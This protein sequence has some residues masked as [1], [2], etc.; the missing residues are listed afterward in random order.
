MLILSTV[1]K[2]YIILDVLKDVFDGIM[3]GLYSAFLWL[4]GGLYTVATVVFELF[5][6]LA[7]GEL[8]S[9]DSYRLLVQNFYIVIGIIM[10]FFLAF[11]ILKGMVNPEEQKKG[12]TAVKTIIIN[13]VTSALMLAVLPSI[14]AFA[15]DF[16]DAIIVEQNTIG[17]F[18]GFGGEGD[19]TP[20]SNLKKVKQGAYQIVNGVYTAFFTVN[21]D[22][23]AE[24]SIPDG[25]SEK[26]K[27][28]YCQGAVVANKT[29]LEA[30]N[31]VDQNGNFNNYTPFSK[32]IV[33]NKV[34]FNFLLALVAGALLIYVGVSYCFDMA[35]RLIKLVF[36]QL[37]A[38]IPIFMR[39]IPDGKMS[40]VFGTW[41]KKTL[42]CYAEVFIRIVLFY[43][44]VY[45]CTEMLKS[46]FM[47]NQVYQYGWFVGLLAKAFTLIGLI[48]FM[49]SAPKLLGDLIPGFDSG[50]MSLGIRD[51]LAAG[52]AL[53]GAAALGAGVTSL[54]RNVSN[55]WGNKENWKAKSGKNKGKVTFGSIA[56]NTLG[57]LGSAAAGATSGLVR[58]GKNALGAKTY[59]DVK[60]SATSGA[61]DAVKARDKRASYKA[62]HDGNGG[63]ILGHAKDSL[64][65]AKRWLIDE[66]LEGLTKESERMSKLAGSY[67][68][69]NDNVEMMLE[70][71]QAKGAKSVFNG[72]GFSLKKYAN[73]DAEAQKLAQAKADFNRGIIDIAALN[74]AEAAYAAAKDDVTKEVMN[75]A[76]EGSNS[77]NY[78]ALDAKAQAAIKDSLVNAEKLKATILENANTKVVQ[79]IMGKDGNDTLKDVLNNGTLTTDAFEHNGSKLKDE[80][81]VEQGKAD[82]KIAEMNKENAAKGEQK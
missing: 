55:K 45:L 62:S 39:I 13:V 32:S 49:R 15:Y 70:K 4:V 1:S 28:D 31:T 78:K 68:A 61:R 72:H 43:F 77:A 65:K 80:A 25:L 17:K 81:K 69:F 21:E 58:G 8:V 36:F 40:G 23:C 59:E 24:Q 6:V 19:G 67:N 20:T 46:D 7:S 14:F 54:A 64:V 2:Y 82:V 26:E 63:V 71:E 75:L 60:K 30:I 27:M 12:T 35:V 52:G 76:L 22:Y 66:S 37:I 11:T 79:D 51:K 41:V 16:Q 5:I 29:L 57:G 56:K 9:A 74:A 44:V 53:T 10:L 48:M 50:S 73:F 3:E 47:S 34:S 38:P 33:E 42:S 18:F